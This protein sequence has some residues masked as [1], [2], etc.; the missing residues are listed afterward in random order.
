MTFPLAT[1]LAMTRGFGDEGRIYGKEAFQIA[2]KE[3]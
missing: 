1:L 2:L 3:V